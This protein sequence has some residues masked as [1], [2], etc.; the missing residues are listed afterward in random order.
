MCDSPPCAAECKYVVEP[1]QCICQDSDD[2]PNCRVECEPDVCELTQCPAC[3][4]YCDP[5]EGCNYACPEIQSSW[6]CRKPLTCQQPTCEL[7]CESPVCAYEG[8]DP[9]IQP[10]TTSPISWSSLIIG[11]V[12]LV[13]VL[14]SR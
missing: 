7:N 12:I 9:W 4:T 14:S 8:P 13:L 3:S 10:T 11:M 6:A 2:V 1:I 5:L